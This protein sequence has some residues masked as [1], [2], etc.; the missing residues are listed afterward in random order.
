MSIV[1]VNGVNLFYEVTGDGF[2]LVFSHEFAGDYRSWA[3]QISYFSRFYRVI[4]YNNRGYP[5]SDIPTNL[6]AYSQDIL[7]D[8][9]HQLLTHLNIAKA[10]IVGLSM[11]GN[12]ALNF[13]IKYPEMCASLV[14]A[15]CGSGST[16]REEFEQNIR[17]VVER[18]ENEGMKTVAEFYSLGRTRIQFKRKDPRGWVNFKDQLAEHSALGSALTL[19]GVQLNRPSI[20]NLEDQLRRLLVPTLVLIG[21][22]DEPCI[23]PAIFMK[24]HIPSAGLAVFPQSGHTINLEEPALFNRVVLDFLT[25]VEREKWAKRD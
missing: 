10:H 17:L 3:P 4:V 13:G 16:N 1:T 2:P 9:L 25:A 21:D 14:V 23:E 12:V 18:L 8:D 24:R 15:G 19:R 20:F 7:I 6:E 22:E 5:P 11:G